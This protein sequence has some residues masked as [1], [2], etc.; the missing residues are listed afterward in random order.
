MF[1]SD[2]AARRKAR[3]QKRKEE[4]RLAKQEQK[5]PEPFLKREI[6]LT[7]A[8]QK[9]RETGI[10]PIYDEVSE[11]NREDGDTEVYQVSDEKTDEQRRAY[12]EEMNKSLT[13][14]NQS[15]M[16][17]QAKHRPTRTNGALK[18][19]KVQRKQRKPS[20]SQS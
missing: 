6:Q 9:Y 20:E 13:Q 12:Q 1:D 7:Q 17:S 3:N 4:K 11:L 5:E 18:N 10:P 15:E 16:F 2:K 8:V 19:P 14:T